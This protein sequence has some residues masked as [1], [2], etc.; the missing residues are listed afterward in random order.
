MK[1]FLF[2]L[3]CAAPTAGF[4]AAPAA[5]PHPAQEPAGAARP[6]RAILQQ[7]LAAAPLRFEANRGQTDRRVQF[8]ARGTGYALWLT[9][10][11]AVMALPA[12]AGQGASADVLRMRFAGAG[13]TPKVDGL[14]RL[15]SQGNYL[16]GQ[17][18]R[19]WRSRVEQYARVHYDNVYPGV[20]LVFYGNQ[21]QLE[22]D[23]VVAPGA[24]PRQIRLDFSGAREVR[25]TPGG[26]L[27]LKTRHGELVQ[28]KPLVYQIERGA[29]KPVA[30]R[31]VLRGGQQVGFQVARYDAGKPLVIDPVLSYS[32][33]LGGSGQDQANGVAVDGS[34]NIY[35][36]GYT[37][38]SDFPLAANTGLAAPGISRDAVVAKFNSAGQLQWSTYL[39]GALNDEAND[40]AVDS[41][42][43]VFVAGAT[44]S[45]NF[46]AVNAA[47]STLGG[48]ADAFVAQL[49]ASGTGLVFSTYLGGSADDQASGLG[50]DAGGNVYVAGFTQSAD[51]P[52]MPGAFQAASGGGTDAFLARYSPAGAKLNATYYGGSGDDRALGLAVDGAGNAY[53]T[54]NTNSTNLAVLNPVTGQNTFHGTQDAFAA[55]LN[56]AGQ[57]L[58]YATYLGGALADFGSGIAVDAQGNAYVTGS[59]NSPDFPVTAG[60]FQ[61]SSAGFI[62]AFALKLSPAGNTLAFSTFLGGAGNDA[63]TRVAADDS[64]VYLVGATDSANFPL[65]S[66]TQGTLGGRADAFV[67]KLNPTGT[68]LLYSTYLGGSDDDQALG[69]A[70]D[71]SRSVY[72]AG[73][74]GSGNFP[75][76]GAF[77]TTLRGQSDAFVSKFTDSGTTPSPTPT[78]PPA[79]STDDNG[80][81]TLGAGSAFDPTLPSLLLGALLYHW[82]RRRVRRG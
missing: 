41:Q 42:G 56:P 26:D 17:D 10:D 51:F 36:A 60:V 49:N 25:V 39:G 71:G 57:A 70:V 78:P 43:N 33:Y 58:L 15:S 47:Q 38:S 77:Q 23:F 20:D 28:R 74:T 69:L 14:E 59:T 45:T 73:E 4:A 54:G 48:Q 37:F 11:E 22:Y 5:L 29:R 9:R 79:S 46:P 27:I 53:L 81:C 34:G 12:P 31:Y 52:A 55:K 66:A 35:V 8:L 1:R 2:A 30:G 13:A 75:V 67:S 82:L 65:L 64:G 72:V 21:R 62:D 3:L 63:A 68:G 61:A 76:V 50:R 80:G 32:T 19:R 44:R 24:D 18:K 40:L 7:S 16:I 6:D